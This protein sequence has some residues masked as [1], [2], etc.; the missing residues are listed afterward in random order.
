[1]TRRP[2]LEI[3]RYTWKAKDGTE[4]PGVALKFGNQ[5]KAHLTPAEA[6]TMADKLHDYADRA[7][8][9]TAS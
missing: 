6:R 4:T 1:M 3:R 8:S 5:V 7:E 9:E 2:F